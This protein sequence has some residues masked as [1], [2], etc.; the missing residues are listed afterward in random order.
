[1]GENLIV[2]LGDVSTK[3]ADLTVVKILFNSILSTPGAK[4]MTGDIKNFYLGTPMTE[5]EYMRIPI[6]AI[7]D[8]IIEEYNLR[9]FMHNGHVYAEIRKGMYGL[10]QA[11]RLANDRLVETLAPFGYR[12]CL[13]TPGLRKH[14]TNSVV[15]TLVVDD[16]GVKYTDKADAE[17]LMNALKQTYEVTEDCTGSRYLGLTI[18]WDYDKRT[19]DLSMPGYIERALQR[20]QHPS[21]RR[22]EHS[23][24]GC[25]A[26]QYGAPIQY[27]TADDDSPLLNAEDS[28]RIQEILCTLLYYA[29]A[30]DPTL[31]TA[32][33]TLASQQAKSTK[34]TMNGVIQLL[35][36]R[37]TNPDATIRYVACDMILHVESD[38]SYLT[39]PKARSRAGGYHYLSNQPLPSDDADNKPP[40]ANGA[41]NILCTILKEVVASAAE[42]EL[43]ALF[44]NAWEACPIRATLEELGHP[45]PPTII[46]TDNST[47]SG[48]VND[49]VKQ[50]RSK[51][52]DMRFYWVRDRVRQG[53]FRIKWRKGCLNKADYFTKHHPASH[54]RAIRSTY[55]YD[56]NNPS[57]NYFELLQDHDDLET[58][59]PTAT[60]EGVLMPPNPA[61]VC[62]P[63]VVRSD[64]QSSASASQQ[65]LVPLASQSVSH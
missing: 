22:P 65:P 44:H 29:R 47:A 61:N 41:I 63:A 19:C 4:F 23:P 35:N 37:A 51:A 16:F 25:Q 8:D 21:P 6:S 28:K 27:D 3:V 32:I 14:D 60:G 10:P 54:H 64:I 36:Y 53:Q 52:M 5:Y 34:E 30:V 15:F 24:H 7:P 42:A 45:Q 59:E 43:A 38:A 56:K 31:L 1:V 39:A 33:N 12:S 55:I 40:P 48:I 26:P 9:V 62:T 20:F 58:A 11:G 13:V 2:Y 50:K 46:I 49:T 57:R 18:N 17:H